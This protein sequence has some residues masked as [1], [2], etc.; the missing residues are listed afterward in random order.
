MTTSPQGRA[1]LRGSPAPV[2][3]PGALAR[4]ELYD[5]RLSLETLAARLAAEAVA[6]G[7]SLQPMLDALD[8]E[9]R[10]LDDADWL[11]ASETSTL[12]HESIVEIGASELLGTL[13]RG[14]S[15]RM[16]WL[17]YLTSARDQGQQSDA[18]HGPVDAIRSGNPR[19][20]EAVAAAHIESGRAPSL[21]VLA[22]DT[23]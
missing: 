5:A 3:S 2:A 11:A 8:A 17:A 22:R 1:T 14:I 7:A 10:A 16:T 6:R 13:M 4:L 23:D 20:A 18:H 9:Q 15:G 12:L 21:A 19:L